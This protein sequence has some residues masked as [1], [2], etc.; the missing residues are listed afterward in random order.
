VQQ[1]QAVSDGE[2]ENARTLLAKSPE[3]P[4][5]PVSSLTNAGYGTALASLQTMHWA[6]AARDTNAM[7]NTVGL[8][9][10][11][12]KRAEELFAQ[13]P[14]ATRQKYGTVDALLV[15]W[16]MNLAENAESY[17]ILSRR[18]QDSEN[19]ALTVQFQYPSGRVRE[20]EISF[21]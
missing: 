8:E 7:L 1:K 6:V 12:R 19:T 17:R 5:V 20:N 10:E 18:D 11:A 13:M 3:I 16:R 9:P 15:D 21:Y 4:M 14:E 2:A